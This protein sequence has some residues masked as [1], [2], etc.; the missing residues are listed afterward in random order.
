M[1]GLYASS[2]LRHLYNYKDI[3]LYKDD[4]LAIISRKNN[5]ELEGLKKNTIKTFNELGFKI[6]IDIGATKYN[7]LD[8]SLDI[9][10][11]TFKPY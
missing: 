2:K 3:G 5:Q 9:A 10:N 8:I 7:F 6:T 1:I 4:G 11:N